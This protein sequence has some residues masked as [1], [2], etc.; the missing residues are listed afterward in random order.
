MSMDYQANI[1]HESRISAERP[2]LKPEQKPGTI[3]SLIQG[4]LYPLITCAVLTCR[5]YSSPF[6]N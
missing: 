6:V 5:K 3:R 2:R 1:Y 4:G